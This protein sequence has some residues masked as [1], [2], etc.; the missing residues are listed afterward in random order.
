MSATSD[1]SGG[2]SGGSETLLRGEQWPVRA[3]AAALDA[4]GIPARAVPP[5]G[6]GEERGWSLEVPSELAADARRV[7]EASAEEAADAEA[8]GP[9]DPQVEQLLAT[10]ARVHAISLALRWIAWSVAALLL[11]LGGAAAVVMVVDA[12][13]ASPPEPS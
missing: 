11:L 5:L 7:L 12:I 3:A 2:V 8:E 1:M 9:P 13:A 10:A 6:S 4:A